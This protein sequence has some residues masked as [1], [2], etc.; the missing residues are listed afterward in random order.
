MEKLKTV[1]IKQLKNNLSAYL[2]EVQLGTTIYV[3]DRDVIVA[4]LREPLLRRGLMQIAN[5]VWVEWISR[6]EVI[7]PASAKKK[8]SPSSVQTREGTALALLDE[9]RKE[10]SK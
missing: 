2:R 10:E 4:E 7:P 1:G 5:P 3:C 8:L 6:G 9:D